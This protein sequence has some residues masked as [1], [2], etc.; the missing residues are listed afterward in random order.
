[1]HKNFSHQGLGKA[2]ILVA[3]VGGRTVL[4]SKTYTVGHSPDIGK[5]ARWSSPALWVSNIP[6]NASSHMSKNIFFKIYTCI[7]PPLQILETTLFPPQKNPIFHQS[8]LLAEGDLLLSSSLVKV[9]H[10]LCAIVR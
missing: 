10:N 9:Q 7:M 1:M 2:H 5:G 4:P 3:L 6:E 8:L